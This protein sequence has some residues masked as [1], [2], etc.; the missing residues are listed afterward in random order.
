MNL[1]IFALCTLFALCAITFFQ[2]QP[3]SVAAAVPT[4]TSDPC[5]STALKSSVA[6]TS[7]PADLVAPVTGESVYVCGFAFGNSSTAG[8]ERLG[9]ENSTGQCAA[10]T[11]TPLTGSLGLNFPIIVGGNHETVLVTPVGFGL[12]SAASTTSGNGYVTYVQK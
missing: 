10:N 11:D 2:A 5:N 3:R 8:S 6:I 7:N 12:C 4:A 9:A 1:R